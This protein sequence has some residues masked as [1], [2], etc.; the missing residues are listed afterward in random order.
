MS[1][2]HD[3]IL[4]AQANLAIDVLK[5]ILTSKNVV[6]FSPYCLTLSM[7]MSYMGANEITESEFKKLLSPYTEKWDYYKVFK[8]SIDSILNFSSE[9]GKSL[10]CKWNIYQGD[11]ILRSCLKMIFRII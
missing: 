8:N 10:Y 9:W 3:D 4:E 1:T 2:Y 6:V 7:A 5:Q 11:V